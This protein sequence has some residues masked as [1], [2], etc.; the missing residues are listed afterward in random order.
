MRIFVRPIVVLV[1]ILVFVVGCD[2]SMDTDPAEY[3]W[4]DT[5]DFREAD[6]GEEVGAYDFEDVG[7]ENVTAAR[8]ARSCPACCCGVPAARRWTL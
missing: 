6:G 4:L 7:G 3:P 2:V 8:S 1:S 5:V